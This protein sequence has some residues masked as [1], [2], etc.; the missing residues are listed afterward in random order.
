MVNNMTSISDNELYE[1]TGGTKIPYIVQRGDTLSKLA[2]KFHCTVEQVC[3]WNNIKDPN[4]I[5]EG[6]K[7]IFKF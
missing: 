7:L 3:K 5:D 6:Q 2:E 1:V 4:K